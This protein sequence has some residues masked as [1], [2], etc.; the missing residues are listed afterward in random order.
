MAGLILD[1]IVFNIYIAKA[2]LFLM[3]KIISIF[4]KNLLNA[5]LEN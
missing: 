5:Y 1:H 2:D 4:K 3:Y